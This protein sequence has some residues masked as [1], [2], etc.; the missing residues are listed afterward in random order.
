MK[1]TL[2][3]L[4]FMLFGFGALYWLLKPPTPPYLKS[5]KDFD[6]IE[7][8]ADKDLNTVWFK[9]TTNYRVRNYVNVYGKIDTSKTK[10]LCNCWKFPKA[11][12][13]KILL[14]TDTE[15]WFVFENTLYEY[16]EIN[17]GDGNF[18]S[19]NSSKVA[20]TKDNEIEKEHKKLFPALYAK[21][22]KPIEKDIKTPEVIK[23]AEAEAKKKAEAEVKKKVE[24][25]DDKTDHSDYWINLDKQSDTKLKED[26]SAI[27]SKIADEAYKCKPG[28]AGATAR[29]I[30]ISRL[31]KL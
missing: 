14:C 6:D 16:R 2:I 4:C 12:D 17:P 18:Y 1:Q 29:L 24:G 21:G 30:I 8:K 7:D 28:S 20:S 23:K 19:D 5:D 25:N 22:I 15:N 11:E 13:R 31:N 26:A 27:R 9:D 3:L 10:P